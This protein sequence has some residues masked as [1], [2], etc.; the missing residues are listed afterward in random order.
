[1]HDS[2]GI[3]IYLTG[4]NPLTTVTMTSTISQPIISVSESDQAAPWMV[5]ASRHRNP[6]DSLYTNDTGEEG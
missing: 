2:V 5:P 1:M 6:E 3:K 4:T